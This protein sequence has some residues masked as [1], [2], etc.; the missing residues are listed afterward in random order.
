[1]ASM[2]VNFQGQ[3]VLASINVI[4]RRAGHS[5]VI[6]GKVLRTS[7]LYPRHNLKRMDILVTARMVSVLWYNRPFQ[8]TD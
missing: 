8:K 1:M 4:V 2:G 7:A 6:G 5:S 3:L